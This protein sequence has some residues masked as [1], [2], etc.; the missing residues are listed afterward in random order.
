MD[1]SSQTSFIPQDSG[2]GIAGA[3]FSSSGGSGLSELVTLL[4]IVIFVASGALAGAVLLYDQ[5][6]T[7]QVAS[8]TAQLKRAEAEFDPSFIAQMTQLDT[9]LNA[10]NSLLT[11]HLA[12]TAFFSG[13]NQA[14]L[15][16]VSFS[17]LQLDAT[18]PQSITLKMTGVAQSV[19][20]IALQDDVFS[21]S[22]MIIGPLFSAI[23]RQQDGVHFDVTA[24][25]NPSAI[26][27]QTYLANQGAA[28][29]VTTM[30]GTTEQS[31]APATTS[32]Q[33]APVNQGG[34][35]QGN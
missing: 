16:T 1:A 31:L 34:V 23:D 15:Q 6:L 32:S 3:R 13:L 2:A 26:S 28:A 8:K 30:P 19:N 9:Q 11:A 14:T 24:E 18:N 20:S 29:P 10:A 21:K 4:A 12:P 5:Y 7:T 25:V 33:T 22:G 27:Y 17:G 35:P